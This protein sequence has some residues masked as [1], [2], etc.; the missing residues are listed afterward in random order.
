MDAE[1]VTQ[2]ARLLC[3]RHL[4]V[5]LGPLYNV[6]HGGEA[7]LYLLHKAPLP[8]KALAFIGLKFV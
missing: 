7:L 1:L 8:L 6:V 4:V 3:Q 5:L 2:Y